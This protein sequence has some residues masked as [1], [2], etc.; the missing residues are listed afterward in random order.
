MKY[1]YLRWIE[2]N[3]YKIVIKHAHIN[4]CLIL[5]PSL[6]GAKTYKTYLDSQKLC[7]TGDL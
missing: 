1:F 3:D 4:W 6:S 5:N 2:C 7:F